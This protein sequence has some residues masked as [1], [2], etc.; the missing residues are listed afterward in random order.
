MY[1]MEGGKETMKS[2]K[3]RR[4]KA[5]TELRNAIRSIARIAGECD[6]D[7]CQTCVF[8]SKDY[9]CIMDSIVTVTG[10]V[11]KKIIGEKK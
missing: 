9:D 1:R 10:P 2:T 11:W 7:E 4:K 5:K 8:M 3:E 6:A